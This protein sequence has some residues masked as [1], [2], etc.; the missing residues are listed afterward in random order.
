MYE[1]SDFLIAHCFSGGRNTLFI[2][3]FV[4]YCALLTITFSPY[5]LPLEQ[6]NVFHSLS[7]KEF[8]VNETSRRHTALI[9]LKIIQKKVD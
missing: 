6:L 1:S 4:Y 7:K 5:L 2:H 8:F 3:S 9:S